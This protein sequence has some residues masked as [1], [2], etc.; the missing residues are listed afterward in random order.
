M[1]L[2]REK[3]GVDPLGHALFSERV[4]QG[5]D[6]L[7][8]ALETPEH[9]FVLKRKPSHWVITGVGSSAAHGKFLSYLINSYTGHT[10]EFWVLSEF[11]TQPHTNKEAGL[12]IFSQG[13]SS[14]AQ[15]ALKKR[16]YFNQCILFSAVS[17][18]TGT[19][20]KKALLLKLKE[21]GIQHIQCTPDNEYT[22]LVRVAGPLTGYLTCL[23]W[24]QYTLNGAIPKLP[25]SFLK[26]LATARR[27][28]REHANKKLLAHLKKGSVILTQGPMSRCSHN[29]AYKLAEGLFIPMP[30]LCDILS[31]SH[32]PFQALC[33]QPAHA[34]L[35]LGCNAHEKRLT[36][37]AAPLIQRSTLSHSIYQPQFC[38]PWTIFEYEMFFNGLLEGLLPLSNADQINWPGKGEDGSLYDLSNL[39]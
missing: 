17:P 6:S 15:I 33:K 23:Q 11:I 36:Q 39:V 38:A 4:Q 13:L 20:E 8:E 21:D 18:S 25:H 24:V 10:A 32:G 37:K 2:P 34:F 22:L 5:L 1:D 16:S 28:G 26:T 29:I 12:I 7:G 31:F 30:Q 14:N 3:R 9:G 27:S 35:L 19:A